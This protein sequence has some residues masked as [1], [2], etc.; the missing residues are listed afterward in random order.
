MQVVTQRGF[1]SLVA[2]LV[3]VTAGLTIGIAVN[4]AG[5]QELQTSLDFSQARR[6]QL[7]ANGCI[8]EGLNKLRTS[9]S[10]FATTL[11]FGNGSCILQVIVL[12]SN[13]TLL[14]TG[15]VDIYNQKIQVQVDS[16]LSV[17]SWQE[18]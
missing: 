14:A 10:S 1:I 2:L 5:L 13:A 18:E 11:S 6:A 4:L 8:E 16:T 7:M 17:V 3:V 12:G 15:T 9:F